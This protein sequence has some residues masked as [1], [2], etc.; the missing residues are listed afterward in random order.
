MHL[1]HVGA[2]NNVTGS[3]SFRHPAVRQRV[4]ARVTDKTD[5]TPRVLGGL[6]G[7][8][9]R[10]VQAL[11]GASGPDAARLGMPVG[12]EPRVPNATARRS[13]SNRM[14]SMETPLVIPKKRPSGKPFKKGQSGNPQGRPK[15]AEAA[16]RIAIR[17]F[18]E[19]L[20]R[21]IGTELRPL[22]GKGDKYT[23]K[24]LLAQKPYMEG[25]IIRIKTGKAAHLEKFIWEHLF[26]KPKVTV[27]EVKRPPES[28][29]REAMKLMKPEEIRIIAA[30]AARV[31]EARKNEA[32]AKALPENTPAR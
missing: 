18:G 12:A 16:G 31:I 1:I 32:A 14:G 3:A 30:A 10:L 23:L 13:S 22:R 20:M 26:G 28:P 19:A 27:E 7:L 8:S 17:E 29:M 11:R 21:D 4:V 9:P 5:K 6:V 25:V 15:G 24:E 2:P